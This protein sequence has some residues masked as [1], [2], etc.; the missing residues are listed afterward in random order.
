MAPFLPR[1]LCAARL[2]ADGD[3]VRAQGFQHHAQVFLDHQM[4]NAVADEAL[5]NSVAQ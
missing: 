3:K 1:K 5:T 2:G 4:G